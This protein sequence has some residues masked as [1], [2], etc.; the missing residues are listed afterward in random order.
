MSQY[1]RRRINRLA[2][3]AALLIATVTLA[4]EVLAWP[5]R[6]DVGDIRIF[7]SRPIPP[8]E[9]MA[10]VARADALV[11]ASPLAGPVPRRRLFLSDGGWRW[12]VASLGA[13]GAF[14]L[15]RPFRN[16]IVVNDADI[17]SDRVRT[18]RA[19]GG[20]RSLSGVI[21]HETAHVVV[22]DRWG[23]WRALRLPGWFFEGLA[24]L[25]AQEGS[26]SDSDYR[27]LVARGEKHPALIYYQGR[28]RVAAALAANGGD[29][30]ALIKTH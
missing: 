29:L 10:V 17:A 26:L 5:H 28:R 25:V 27:R 23:E 9:M 24:D 20:E 14:A 3:V 7:A 15:R 11:A 6:T 16:A 2:G 13:P 30:D 21:A 1:V 19:V 22:A 8:T 18:G 4:P 12:H